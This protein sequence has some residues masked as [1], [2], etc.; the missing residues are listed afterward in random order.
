M[1]RLSN[2]WKNSYGLTKEKSGFG[3]WT[4]H[5]NLDGHYFTK[6]IGTVPKVSDVQTKALDMRDDPNYKKI[7]DLHL[8]SFLQFSYISKIQTET[9][10]HYPK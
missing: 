7:T 2:A 3:L 6:A 10:E 4:P 5:S 9:H 8:L 1:P